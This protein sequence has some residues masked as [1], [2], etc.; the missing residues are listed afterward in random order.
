MLTNALAGGVLIALYLGILILQLNPQVSVVSSTASGWF[1][2]LLATY[3]TYV[4]VLI[5]L[6]I[7]GGEAI[8]SRPLRPGWLSV[9]ILAW[10][11]AASS[12]AAAILTWSNLHGMQSML[13]AAAAD[14]M[15]EGATATTVCAIVLGL[16]AILRY[17]F[18]R[19]GNRPAAVLMVASVLASLLVPIWIRGPGELKV[20]SMKRGNQARPVSQ[21]PRVRM[22]LL[23]GASKGFLLQ[24]VAAGQLPNFGKLIDRGAVID[25]ATLRPTQAEPVWTAAATGKY[26][27][28]NGARSEYLY[29]VDN[30]ETDP[31]DLLPDY[32]F[33]QALLYQGFVRAE[34]ITALARRA[35]PMWEILADYSVPS[36]I[37]NWP[38]TRPA[39]GTY[40]FLI[41]DYFDEATSSPIRASDPKAGDPTTAVNIARK[42]FDRWQESPWSEVLPT[43]PSADPRLAGIRRARWD[44]AYAEAE[45]ELI[46][47]F[48]PR[49][50]ALRLEGIDEFGHEFLRDAETD[51]MR[52][53]PGVEGERSPLDRYYAVVDG[54]LERLIAQTEPGDL[55]IVASGY[56]IERT[57]LLK[58]LLARFLGQPDMT[59]THEDA[60]DGF[61]IAFG[62]NVQPGE[63]KGGSVVDI[64]PTVLYYMGI[65][66]GRDM[67]G[68]ARTDLFRIAYTQEHPVTYTQT[69]ER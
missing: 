49:L 23:D 16:V 56:G 12:A 26:P 22:L 57:P 3:G 51:L 8:I 59:G 36:G 33:A 41:S 60:P 4:T 9:R 30:A 40:G 17:S 1:R 5:V 39:E 6:A 15:R 53:A 35:R 29:R 34:P 28:K 43:F 24:H 2:A 46:D 38:L 19:R 10:L 25:L 32:C 14:R 11:S 69:H 47:W 42:V 18:G 63:S 37:V 67:D 55:L 50:T 66:I 27:P 21:P 61:L 13:S 65:P 45:V 44:G 62:S 58:R 20:P 54:Y 31:V 52:G 48:A 64:A 7:L 68:F